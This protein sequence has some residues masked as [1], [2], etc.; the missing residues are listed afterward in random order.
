MSFKTVRTEI[1]TQDHSLQ[2]KIPLGTVKVLI[3]LPT[4][5]TYIKRLE[6]S[7]VAEPELDPEGDWLYLEPVNELE[8]VVTISGDYEAAY[9]D[10]DFDQYIL[11]DLFKM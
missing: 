2:F 1:R 9:V 6:V 4:S 5:K 8:Q 7:D 3:H 11:F 10:Q